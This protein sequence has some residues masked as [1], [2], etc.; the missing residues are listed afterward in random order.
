VV[1]W[2][3]KKIETYTKDELEKE[4]EYAYKV[5]EE[6]KNNEI[7]K[8]SKSYKEN[9]NWNL[10]NEISSLAATNIEDYIRTRKLFPQLRELKSTYKRKYFTEK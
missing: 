6:L 3:G 10:F 2:R 5:A 8:L 1:Y 4:I 7:A 9:N